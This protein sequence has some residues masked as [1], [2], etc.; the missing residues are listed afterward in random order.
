MS[1]AKLDKVQTELKETI[2]NRAPC[3]IEPPIPVVVTLDNGVK[4]KGEAY[5]AQA[6]SDYFPNGMVMVRTA[7]TDIGVPINYIRGR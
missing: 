7:N 4:Y 1:K 2:E 3:T 5:E 6:E